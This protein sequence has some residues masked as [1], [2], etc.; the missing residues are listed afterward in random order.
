MGAD[1]QSG[2]GTTGYIINKPPPEGPEHAAF[3]DNWNAAHAG[4]TPVS[5]GSTSRPTV[6]GAP[7]GKRKAVAR[8][9]GKRRGRLQ[10]QRQRV[11]KARR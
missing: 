2:Y 4:G 8:G 9:R 11:K 1:S 6:V 5:G 7:G 10:Q 3:W